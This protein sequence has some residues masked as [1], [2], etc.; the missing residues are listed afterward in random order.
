MI[1]AIHNSY[2][3]FFF[4]FCTL[5]FEIV[6]SLYKYIFIQLELF[7]I[8]FFL[9]FSFL[10]LFITR[11]KIH[12]IFLNFQFNFEAQL[13]IVQTTSTVN[14]LAHFSSKKRIFLQKVIIFQIC[15]YCV[16]VFKKIGFQNLSYKLPFCDF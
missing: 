16:L 7:S 11:I 3:H 6:G 15:E 9:F 12:K 13:E 2:L 1:D 4:R 14:H 8:F 10:E 5:F